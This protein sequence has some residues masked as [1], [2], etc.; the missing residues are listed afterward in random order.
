M[1]EKLPIWFETVPIGTGA[2]D[3]TERCK[4]NPGL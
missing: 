2:V 4:E 3:G 1:F